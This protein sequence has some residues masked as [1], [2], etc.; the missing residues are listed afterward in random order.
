MTLIPALRRGTSRARRCALTSRTGA[1][2]RTSPAATIGSPSGRQQLPVVL[3]L[4]R[5]PHVPELAILAGR[6][7]AGVD[8]RPPRGSARLICRGGRALP[9]RA[10]APILDRDRW[11]P[12]IA[13][14]Q[15]TPTSPA[16]LLISLHTFTRAAISDPT[17]S[18]DGAPIRTWDASRNRSFL[19]RLGLLALGDRVIAA[20]SVLRTWYRDSYTRLNRPPR[21][22]RIGR[23]CGIE[24]ELVLRKSV[25]AQRSYLSLDLTRRPMHPFC[26]DRRIVSATAVGREPLASFAPG[27]TLCRERMCLQSS[28]RSRSRNQASLSA[29]RCALNRSQPPRTMVALE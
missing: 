5:A 24:D 1:P 23:P 11:S 6:M 16:L 15:P 21:S 2:P 10:R 8:N 26:Y 4:V 7:A 27:L 18:N 9:L 22:S 12:L 17:C 29:C 14:F 25:S 28:D 19:P 13:T 20:A 3:T